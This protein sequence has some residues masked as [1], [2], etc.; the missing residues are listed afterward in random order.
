MTLNEQVFAQAQLL[1]GELEGRKYALL[2]ALCS[3]KVSVLTARLRRGL[4]PDDC[5]ADFIA[6]ASLLALAD[7][8]CI[9]DGESIAEVSAGDFKIKKDSRDA[10]SVCLRTQAELLIAPYLTDA[11]AFAGV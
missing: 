7:L 3:A 9:G 10:A 6:A 5:K 8:D 1:A 2:E 11:F 4:R